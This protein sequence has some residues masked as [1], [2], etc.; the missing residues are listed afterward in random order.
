MK[1][2]G[3]AEHGGPERVGWVDIPEPVVGP[4]EVVVRLR[5]AG[6]NRLDGFVLAGI[7][8]VPIERPHVVGSDGAGLVEARGPGVTDLEVGAEVLLQPGL[9]DGTCDACRS[10]DE[11]L[12]RA[13]R[14]VGEHTQGTATRAIAIPRGNVYPKPP[15]MTFEEAAAVPLVFQTAWR[16][17]VT[18]GEVRAGTTV[19]IVGAGGGVS[20]AAVQIAKLRGARVVVASRS[21]ERAERTKA[22]G[23]DDAVAFGDADPL[24]RVLWQWSGK[25]GVDVIFDSVGAPTVP[26]SVRALA[27]GGRLVVIGAT[28]GPIA[29]ID[30]RPLFWRQSSI[31]G[32]TMASRREFD[33]VLKELSAGRLR[34]VVA[35]AG[36]W[37]DAIA[38]FREFLTGEPFGKVVVS[39]PE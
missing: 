10:G 19:A 38:T 4:G 34:P 8:G 15:T 37:D 29:E 11:S 27:R 23:A 9:S 5:A 12:C 6:F 39:L 28:A 7:P 17:L 18:I 25:R 22:L 20:T 31:R 1:G 24:E 16:A 35:R 3:F 36:A 2:L 13:F 33:A 14:I 21:I 26:R 30:L 32:S